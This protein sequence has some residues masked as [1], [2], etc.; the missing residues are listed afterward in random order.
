MHQKVA[1]RV[2]LQ[3]ITQF[4]SL[5]ALLPITSHA[6]TTN[7]T[8]KTG[9]NSIT[10]NYID[11]TKL[12]QAQVQTVLALAKDC[13]LKSPARVRTLLTRPTNHRLISVQSTV[14]TNGRKSIFDEVFINY[15]KWSQNSREREAGAKYHGDFWVDPPCLRTNSYTLVQIN[16]HPVK[17]QLDEHIPLPLA[18]K[19]LKCF[20]EGKIEFPTGMRMDL[21]R[22]QLQK[23]FDLEPWSLKLDRESARY[24][25][26]TS[27]R[28]RVI[29]FTFASEKV[30]IL[31][32]STVHY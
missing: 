12:T 18:D 26:F 3:L 31:S 21:T 1:I 15:S 22:E 11:D 16:N 10:L 29:Y 32:I 17:L 27:Q 19:M 30:R 13:G 14:R 24:Q 25:L 4:L 28:N 5:C 6:Q 9:T 2:K 8:T 23:L 20:E 7:S